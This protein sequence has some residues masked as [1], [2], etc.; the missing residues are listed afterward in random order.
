VARS[1]R[2]Q[3][4]R[5]RDQ[6]IVL[7]FIAFYIQAATYRRP[8]RRFLNNFAAQ[9]RH[10]DNLPAQSI[11]QLFEMCTDLLLHGVGRSALRF[12]GQQ[13]NAAF[14]EALLV[15]LA[16]RID[17]GNS[18]APQ[19]VARAVEQVAND[20]DVSLVVTSATADEDSVRK[21]LAIATK[22]FLRS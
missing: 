2:H 22:A 15:G 20:R 16:R 19:D 3:I 1:L 9:Y 21:R 7:R 10:L 8:L 17:L 13:V 4:P 12:G 14:T 18:P 5:L 11:R 6:E